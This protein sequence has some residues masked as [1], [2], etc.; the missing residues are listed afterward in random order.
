[1]IS[2]G[3]IL[4]SGDQEYDQEQGGRSTNLSA[5]KLMLLR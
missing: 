4:V 5:I 2:F 1:M 3:N